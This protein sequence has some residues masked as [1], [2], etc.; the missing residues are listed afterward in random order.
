MHAL[1]AD[2]QHRDGGGP[3]PTVVRPLPCRAGMLNM[4]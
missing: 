1:G 4:S 3:P 2:I